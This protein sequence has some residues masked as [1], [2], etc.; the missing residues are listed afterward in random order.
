MGFHFSW[1]SRRASR[2]VS[3]CFRCSSLMWL[4][5]WAGEGLLLRSMSPRGTEDGR[6]F[7]VPEAPGDTIR[8]SLPIRGS[9]PSLMSVERR[10]KTVLTVNENFRTPGKKKER[11]LVAKAGEKKGFLQSALSLEEHTILNRLFSKDSMLENGM[12]PGKDSPSTSPS[13]GQSWRA[14]EE[15]L[16]L[17]SSRVSKINK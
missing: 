12:V 10:T 14:G 5:T 2:T 7:A 15:R 11:T 8:F 4:L 17:V 1:C 9:S 3:T 16:Y 13:S 6:E